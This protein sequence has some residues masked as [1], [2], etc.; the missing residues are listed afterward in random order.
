MSRTDKYTVMAA[1]ARLK[2]A[3]VGVALKRRGDRLSMIATLPPK[4]GSAALRPY[5]QVIST[6]LRANPQGVQLAE[7]E[8]RL[9]GARIASKTFEWDQYRRQGR[10]GSGGLCV[11]A[12]I[13]QF[14]A[15]YRETHSLSDSTWLNQWVKV[16][17]QLPGDALLTSDLLVREAIAKPRDTRLRLET[18]RKLQ[19]LADFAGIEIDLLQFKGNYGPSKVQPRRLPSDEEIS[20][21]YYRIPNRRW[22]WVYG[23]LAAGALRPHEAFFCEWKDARLEVYK[24]KTGPRR[25]LKFFYPEWVEDWRLQDV[26]LP[27]IDAEKA[28]GNTT[29]GAKVTRQLKRYGVPFD[30]YD[31][32]HAAAVRMSVVFGLPVTVAA[33]IMGHSPTE[34][35][36]TYHKHINNAEQER[37]IA[38][39]MDASDRPKPPAIPVA[40]RPSA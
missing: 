12:A 36:R 38:R 33:R 11:G 5:Q 21:W 29:L 22:Q 23:I 28:Y 40:P 19:H 24:G 30:A 3:L 26:R 16:F 17:R 39:V 18:C 35:T 9:L 6:G 8:A 7:N 13:A 2:A 4:P 10:R 15:R 32:R 31:L 1:N 27:E 25:V 34:H 20:E 37:A 14:E